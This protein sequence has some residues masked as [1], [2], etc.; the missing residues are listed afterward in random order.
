MPVAD[1]SGINL[2]ESIVVPLSLPLSFLSLLRILSWLSDSPYLS[3][4]KSVK[5]NISF[6]FNI[7]LN[8]LH[9]DKRARPQG[10]PEISVSMNPL[11]PLLR[12]LSWLH[13]AIWADWIWFPEGL[14][15]ADLKDHDGMVFPKTSDLWATIPIAL[16]FLVIRQIF[17]RSAGHCYSHRFVFFVVVAP[18]AC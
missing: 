3:N 15:W 14:G 7:F 6:L 16:C 17:E 11:L 1:A 9:Q 18:C 5:T 13:E 4:G 12:M 10:M 8:F 2:S